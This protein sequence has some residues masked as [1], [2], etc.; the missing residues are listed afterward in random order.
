[1]RI[2]PATMSDLDAAAAIAGAASQARLAPLLSRPDVL[3]LIAEWGG[4]PTGFLIAQPAPAVPGAGP[5]ATIEDFHV[6]DPGLWPSAGQAL[7]REA[8]ALLKERGIERIAVACGGK[9]AEKMAM[10]AAEKLSPAGAW[11]TANV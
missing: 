9:D 10:L 7:L 6:E 4:S 11:L 1:M 5:A 2:R 8:R 3:F